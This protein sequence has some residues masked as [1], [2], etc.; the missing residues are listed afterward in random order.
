[1]SRSAILPA[2]PLSR[3]DAVIL[4]STL[5]WGTFWIPLRMLESSGLA[6][7]AATTVSLFLGAALLLPLALWRSRALFRLGRAG[8]MA[9]FLLALAL[10]LYA[11]GLLRGQVARVTLLF[12]LTPVWSVLLGRL[13]LAEPITRRRIATI[14]LGLCG[15]AVVF[16]A[17]AGLP[18]P[19]GLGDW[20]GLISG[21][22]WAFCAVA[23]HRTVQKGVF[24]RVF[25]CFLFLGPLFF[26]LTL[27]PGSR[28]AMA[29]DF[30]LAAPSLLW[31][32][33]FAGAWLIPVAAMTV[34]GASRIDP[35]RLAIFLMFEVVIAMA[36]AAILIDEPFGSREVAG[37]CLILGASLCELLP[38]RRRTPLGGL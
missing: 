1:M 11:E 5:L 25:L 28:A 7:G 2:I 33:A 23:L 13:L 9:G 17:D 16:G 35:G 6:G 14:L 12:Y 3:P 20:M 31:L 8:V 22:A 18:L 38:L 30:G 36:T 27:L 32:A 34:Y 37:A 29:V 10:A 21:M 19:R 24:D 26:L 15:M 4:A